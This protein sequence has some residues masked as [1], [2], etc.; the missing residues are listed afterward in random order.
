MMKPGPAADIVF[1]GKAPVRGLPAGRQVWG[2]IDIYAARLLM[3]SFFLP[4]KLQ[5]L[6][7]MVSG[8]YF[9][10]RS[11]RSK[12]PVPGSNYL[13]ALAISS[14]YLLYL[15]A[16]PFTPHEY[17]HFLSLLCQQK[18]SLLLMPFVF[19]ITAQSFR[20][21][22]AGELIYLVYGCVASCIVG[23]ADFAWH[24]WR[25]KEAAHSLSHVQYRV[26]FERSTGIH[27]TYMSMFLAF[28]VCITLLA[29]PFKGI[30]KYLLVY[31]L[32]IFLLALLAKSPIIALVVILFHYA[33]VNRKGLYRYKLV[34]LGLLTSLA[35]ACFFIPFIGQRV[36]E[37]FQFA[38]VG[39]PGNVMDNSVY[40]RKLIWTVDTGLLR[41]YWLTGIGPGRV[42]QVLHERYFFYSVTNHFFVGYFDPHNEYFSEWLS[43][44]ILGF[45]L[46]L[47]VLILHAVKALRTKNYLYQYLLTILFITFSTETLLSRQEGVLFFSVFTSLFFFC[48]KPSGST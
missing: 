40:V 7:V 36:K 17:R 29:A 10:V 22:I 34:F 32:L 43:F 45:L 2:N 18:A 48:S 33:Y 41:H 16:V 27:P 13:W 15:L 23:N 8:L 6:T 9:V 14:F 30:L 42:L 31:A 35:A 3:L 25:A 46:F 38:G 20:T 37:V 24:I 28:S 11:V 47:S 44:G 21:L 12:E 19:A 26:M 4:E 1:S 5:A 39:K